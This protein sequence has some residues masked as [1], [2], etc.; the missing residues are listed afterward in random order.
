MANKNPS[1]QAMR[2]RLMAYAELYARQ[3]GFRFK[4]DCRVLLDNIIRDATKNIAE[5]TRLKR[6]VPKTE[7]YTRQAEVGLEWIVEQMID[8][9]LKLPIQRQT[10]GYLGEDTFLPIIKNLCPCWPF[11]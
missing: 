8:N 1:K 2:I 6:N 11:C 4:D 9:W 10:P 5:K 3:R 7:L